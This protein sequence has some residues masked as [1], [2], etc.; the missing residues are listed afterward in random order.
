V[1]RPAKLASSLLRAV[2]AA[3]G[4]VCCLS[5]LSRPD[6]AF[7]SAAASY[8]NPVLAR[9]FPDPC[10]L[11]APDGVYY[12]YGSGSAGARVQVASSP[13]L[14]SWTYHGEGLTKP[15][16]QGGGSWTPDVRLRG[17]VYFMYVNVQ[18]TRGVACIAVATSSSPAGPFVDA[19]GAPLVCSPSAALGSA[20]APFAYDD[21]AT[22][23][24][25]YGSAGAPIVAVE[26][27]A[28]RTAVAGAPAALLAPDAGAP[29]EARLVEAAWL[30]ARGGFTYL[31]YSGD[32]CCG[33]T[34]RYAVSV[35]RSAAGARGPFV[36]MGA[37]SGSDSSVVLSA[38]P[39]GAFA[40]PGHN[41]VVTDA[42]GDDW[43]V[44]H[45]YAAAPAA[46]G[47]RTLMLDKILWTADGW[48]FVGSP[49]TTP[50]PAP[51]VA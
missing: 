26:L 4:V 44:Y 48:P 11:R 22:P 50:Q 39:G 33:A 28:N 1:Y 14:V 10:V 43:L 7:G 17:G 34:A 2:A 5:G 19:R 41:A 15:S 36:K 31:F 45:A 37:A 32:K 51:V 16:W 30:H 42:A 38:G 6:A 23:L 3:A 20:D 29:Y 8:V 24:L 35:A 47:N 40:A 13:D 49:S 25:L 9:D 46:G 21:G 18:D 27:A 12:A